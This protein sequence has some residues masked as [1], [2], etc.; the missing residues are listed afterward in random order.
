[1]HPI[2][3]QKLRN[4]KKVFFITALTVASFAGFAQDDKKE[5]S[6]PFTFSVGVEGALPLGD[7]GDT[8]NFGIGGSIQGDYKVA[9]ELAITLNVGYISYSGKSI[10]VLP[11]FP[12]V[13]VDALGL[14]PVLAGIKYWFSPN[15]YGSGQL[16][17]SFATGSG[18]GSNFT[19]APGIGFQVQKFDFL[20]KYTGISGDGSSLNS[21]GLRAAYNF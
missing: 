12:T 7:F 5:A 15:V 3:N 18:S 13:K 1:M 21:I 14:V 17:L 8:Y 16:G 10:T 19:Y 6:K 11:G 9:D 4:M 20:L 2:I